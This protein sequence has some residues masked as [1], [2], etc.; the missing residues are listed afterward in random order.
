MSIQQTIFVAIL[1]KTETR[2]LA[3]V[4]SVEEA[5]DVL[6]SDEVIQ[7]LKHDEFT[8]AVVEEL[9]VRV[10]ASLQTLCCFEYDDKLCR[11]VPTDT[12]ISG[13]NFSIK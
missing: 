6:N 2:C 7:V 3:V 4:Q 10:F 1:S 12:V 8:H 5:I 9:V 11:W 13:N